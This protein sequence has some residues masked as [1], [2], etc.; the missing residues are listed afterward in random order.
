MT[1][2]E[3]TET[4]STTD[5]EGAGGEKGSPVVDQIRKANPFILALALV[6]GAGGGATGLTSIL[7]HHNSGQDCRDMVLRLELSE[8]QLEALG[9]RQNDGNTATKTETLLLDAEL[10]TLREQVREL[11]EERRTGRRQPPD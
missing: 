11:R 2:E 10:K 8:E 6:L 4:E 1:D 7:D 9:H 3:C 5:C